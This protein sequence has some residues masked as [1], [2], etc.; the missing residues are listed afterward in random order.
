MVGIVVVVFVDNRV[1]HD[2]LLVDREDRVGRYRYP[3]FCL[4]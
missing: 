4:V 2:G 1:D 3:G